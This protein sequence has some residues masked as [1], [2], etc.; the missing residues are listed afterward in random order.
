MIL[1]EQEFLIPLVS[2]IL[3]GAVVFGI[4]HFLYKQ[5]LKHKGSITNTLLIIKA[6]LF[7]G[8]SNV[9]LGIA[10]F[11]LFYI[12][13]LGHSPSKLLTIFFTILIIY[14]LFVIPIFIG[15][16]AISFVNYKKQLI[17]IKNLILTVLMNI[18]CIVAFIMFFYMCIGM[19]V[20]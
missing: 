18:I 4:Y 5:I 17:T 10:L 12:L 8:S 11:T 14:I 7:I 15:S 9:L 3:G 2:W 16:I 20:Y 13:S 1:L 19:L 6:P